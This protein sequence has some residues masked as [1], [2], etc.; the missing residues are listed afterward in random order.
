MRD[1]R[2]LGGEHRRL[3]FPSTHLIGKWVR[4]CGL[5]PEEH[6]RL[7]RRDAGRFEDKECMRTCVSKASRNVATPLLH[8]GMNSI[9]KAVEQQSIAMRRI[10]LM[11]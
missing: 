4:R 6:L 10:S 9:S 7:F 11:N 2:K 1:I 3:T 5:Y 8:Y